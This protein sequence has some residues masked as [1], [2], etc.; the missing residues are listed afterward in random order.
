VAARDQRTYT[1]FVQ[2]LER[3]TPVVCDTC[4]GARGEPLAPNQASLLA[5]HFV[6]SSCTDWIVA[7]IN[8]KLQFFEST[9]KDSLAL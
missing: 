5:D 9:H 2:D 1:P 8:N 4:E 6:N 7:L 3:G